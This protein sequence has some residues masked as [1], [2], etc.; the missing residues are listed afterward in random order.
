M[1]PLELAEIGKT[2]LKVSNLGVGGV[3]IGRTST[4]EESDETLKTCVEL[5]VRYFDTAPNLYHLS[6]IGYGNKPWCE[7]LPGLEIYYRIG[8][9]AN[10][11]IAIVNVKVITTTIRTGTGLIELILLKNMPNEADIPKTTIPI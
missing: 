11:R 1:D 10:T 4:A 8:R 5:G 6:W 2:G 7:G 3:A 9:S